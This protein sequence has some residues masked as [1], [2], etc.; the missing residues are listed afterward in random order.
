MV[1]KVFWAVMAAVVGSILIMFI[2]AVV[3]TAG[4]H[5]GDS[6]GG[7]STAAVGSLPTTAPPYDPVATLRNAEQ[8]YRA[9]DYA[10]A[11]VFL[12]QLHTNDLNQPRTHALWNSASAHLDH[13]KNVQEVSDRAEYA[14]NYES[15]LLG[16]GMDATVRAQ[17]AGNKTLYVSYPL[18]SRPLVYQIMNPGAVTNS[19]LAEG[20]VWQSLMDDGTDLPSLWR[21][22]GFD[23]VI[24]T[25][26]YETEWRYKLN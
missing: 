24:L 18:M 25:D 5:S 20:H 19:D 3:F 4:D 9:K 8:A 14:S 15:A 7:S 10:G 6:V 11:V 26:G 22:K 13:Q 16:A 1:K 12:S 17:G 23:R 2:I 21:S